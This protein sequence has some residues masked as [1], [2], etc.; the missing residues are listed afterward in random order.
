MIRSFLIAAVL[1]TAVAGC[2]SDEES[3]PEG[4]PSTPTVSKS[5][6]DSQKAGD[7]VEVIMENTQ[8][9]PMDVTVPVGGTITWTNED[10]F[11]HTVTKESGPGAD[12]D[13]GEVEGGGTY[14]ETFDE[15]GT[16]DYL[17][18]IHPGQTGTITVEQ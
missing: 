8:F 11:A 1:A 6:S 4:P 12:F 9:L 7:A 13:S 15:A 18:T 5:E 14:S 10:P 17:C 3:A 2:G 16:I